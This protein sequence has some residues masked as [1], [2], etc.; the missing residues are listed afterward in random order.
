MQSIEGSPMITQYI[1][2]GFPDGM[3]REEVVQGMHGV[4]RK[5]RQNADL[6]RK[7]FLY[8]PAN[9]KTGAFYL[10]KN[11]EAAERAHGPEWRKGILDAFGS[12]PVIQYFETP[13]VVDNALGQ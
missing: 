4:T 3:S 12:E 10:W 13:L 6:I 7:T 5:W 1:M 11:R 8:D 9:Q 2:F